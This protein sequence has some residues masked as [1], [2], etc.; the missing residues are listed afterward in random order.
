MAGNNVLAVHEERGRL[1]AIRV[2][3]PLLAR[4]PWGLSF[5]VARGQCGLL[6]SCAQHSRPTRAT[7]RKS[8]VACSDQIGQRP[9]AQLRTFDKTN[10][11]DSRTTSDLMLTVIDIV[12]RKHNSLY[13]YVSSSRRASVFTRTSAALF[14]VTRGQRGIFQSRAQHSRPTRAAGS[15][16]AKLSRCSTR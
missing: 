14:L 7:S 11:E 13:T 9:V 15:S 2:P 16:R 4:V 5:L 3:T 6:Q 12:D 10:S 8:G 1:R